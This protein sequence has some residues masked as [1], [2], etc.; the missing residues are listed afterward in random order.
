MYSSLVK[1]I[2]GTV[3]AFTCSKINLSPIEVVL[4]KCMTHHSLAEVKPNWI[5]HNQTNPP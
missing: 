2:S 5:I 3:G 1:L 4:L